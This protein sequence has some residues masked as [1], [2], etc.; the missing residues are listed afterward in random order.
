ML[1]NL[2]PILVIR[3]RILFLSYQ[4]ISH[5]YWCFTRTTS[6]NVLNN[7]LL[8]FLDFIQKIFKITPTKPPSAF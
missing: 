3:L 8:K 4:D 6:S 5:R 2:T 1:L 7:N